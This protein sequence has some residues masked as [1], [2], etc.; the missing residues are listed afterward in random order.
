MDETLNS[1]N[2]EPAEVVDS[3][4]NTA[5]VTTGEG[6][7]AVVAEQP[8]TE[9]KE[10]KQSREENAAFKSARLDAE[11]RENA[12]Y[13]YAATK[14]GLANLD[15]SPVKTKAE[16]DAAIEAA[17]KRNALIMAGVSPEDAAIRIENEQLKKAQ[18]DRDAQTREQERAGK[19]VSDLKAYFEEVNG[20]KLTETDA[21]ELKKAG[22]FELAITEKIPLKR[23]YDAIYAKQQR[24]R[25]KAIDA[26][27]KTQEANAQNATTS[28]GS[29]T[30]GGTPDNTALTD[31]VIANM[32][33]K[34]MA[35]RWPEIKKFYNMK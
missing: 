13:E 31:E 14:I 17:E 34:E 27:K 12:A 4:E 23:A 30:G 15:G 20:R 9:A 28:T 21:E 6:E 7:S 29:V 3:Q 8:V 18:A 35:R 33:Q 32:S 10:P 16:Y 1:V 22:L 24:E 2:A 11:R 19:E 5:E 25:L 26:G